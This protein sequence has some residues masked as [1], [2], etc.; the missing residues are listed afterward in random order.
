MRDTKFFEPVEQVAVEWRGEPYPLPAFYYDLT[1]VMV[2]FLTPVKKIQ[3]LLPSDRLY[4]MRMMPGKA[5]TTIIFYEYRDSDIGPYNEMLIGFP[6]TIDGP[7]PMGLGLR[8]AGLKGATS[9]IWHLPVTTEIARDMGIDVAGYPK[10]LAD[11]TFDAGGRW[12]TCRTEAAG[13]HVLTLSVRRPRTKLVE[14]RWPVEA[15]TVRDRW[16]QRTPAVVNLRNLGSTWRAGSVR[17]ETGDHPIGRE[18]ADLGLGRPI[19]LA[20]APDSQLI[21]TRPIEGWR[22]DKQ[23][24]R[25]AYPE[26]RSQP[27]VT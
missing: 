17:L 3:A 16:V 5:V 4:P 7:A 26:G 23:A 12:L 2:H 10:I 21:L 11:I 22:A 14:R 6:V 25:P 8:T 27:S 15:V 9:F 20:Y 13:Q 24:T 18:V 1:S 19:A